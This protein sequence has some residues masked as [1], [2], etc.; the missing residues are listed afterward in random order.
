[1]TYTLSSYNLKD[2]TL[3]ILVY[4]HFNCSM[5]V[6]VCWSNYQVNKA[7]YTTWHKSHRLG[8]GTNAQ[9][10]M[11]KKKGVWTDGPTNQPTNGHTLL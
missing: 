4:V 11:R 2:R 5:N 8:R 6:Y 1:M 3:K 7:G 10:S 9:K